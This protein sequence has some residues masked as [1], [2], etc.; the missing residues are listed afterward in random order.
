MSG[1]PS[2]W[3]IARN[4]S[5]LKVELKEGLGRIETKLDKLDYVAM[6]LYTSERD[7]LTER[8][9]ELEDDKKWNRRQVLGAIIAS[10]VSLIITFMAV[11]GGL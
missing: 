4:V 9:K 1:E 10:V 2:T 7:R 5:T 3:E 11:Q 6:T 8:I